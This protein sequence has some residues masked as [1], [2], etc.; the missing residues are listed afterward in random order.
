MV[1]MCPY[2]WALYALSVWAALYVLLEAAMAWRNMA[3]AAAGA[4]QG[5]EPGP[6]LVAGESGGEGADEE[7]E[8]DG[9]DEED[10]EEED[11]DEEDEDEEEEGEAGVEVMDMPPLAAQ[12]RGLAVCHRR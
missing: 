5:Y 12:A 3:A 8:E 11:E 2:K 1:S 10:D 7:E 6:V 9:E 4:K